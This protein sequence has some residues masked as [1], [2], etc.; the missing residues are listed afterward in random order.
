[1]LPTR[2]WLEMKP[3]T[4]SFTPARLPACC[5]LTVL[6]R[7]SVHM[8]QRFGGRLRPGALRLPDQLEGARDRQHA[9]VVEALAGDLQADRQPAR[10]VAAIDR[11][12]RLLRH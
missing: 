6:P 1:M 11:R 4:K 9:Q 8:L 12:C 5:R 3:S 10:G 7:L 2:A